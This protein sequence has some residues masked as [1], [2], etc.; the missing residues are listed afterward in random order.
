MTIVLKKRLLIL[1]S[2]PG[3]SPFL[4]N[5]VISLYAQL[6]EEDAQQCLLFSSALKF[7]L[8]P[9]ELLAFGRRFS[10]EVYL[11]GHFQ[12]TSE[13][14]SWACGALTV[15]AVVDETNQFVDVSRSDNIWSVTTIL[16]CPGDAIALTYPTVALKTSLPTYRLFPFRNDRILRPRG[17]IAVPCDGST[18]LSISF[19][20]WN[21][22]GRPISADINTESLRVDFSV[23]GALS[24]YGKLFTSEIMDVE[25]TPRTTTQ[26][27]ALVNVTVD[28]TMDRTLFSQYASAYLKATNEHLDL[29]L[30]AAVMFNNNALT[31][32]VEYNNHIRFAATGLCQNLLDIS[33]PDLPENANF[34]LIPRRSYVLSAIEYEKLHAF[35]VQVEIHASKHDVFHFVCEELLHTSQSLSTRNIRSIESKYFD[36]RNL[37]LQPESSSYNVTITPNGDTTHCG[38]ACIAT[39]STVTSEGLSLINNEMG[40]TAPTVSTTTS[41]GYLATVSKENTMFE[42]TAENDISS[43]TLKDNDINSTNVTEP[44]SDFLCEHLYMRKNL[45]FAFIFHVCTSESCSLAFAITKTVSEILG[46]PVWLNSTHLLQI[47]NVSDVWLHDEALFQQCAFA[48]ETVDLKVCIKTHRVWCL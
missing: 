18:S 36:P 21:C 1:F 47:T 11:E 28:V 8:D 27:W 7:M 17:G 45:H 19:R 31:D 23:E 13:L 46:S 42:E 5:I 33:V 38:E 2:L 30:Q 9:D 41:K 43:N 22:T 14:A 4:G 32:F 29:H 15:K 16:Q 25:I 48:D 12:T 39:I 10:N 35:L 24:I 20:M 26:A 44:Q 3:D 37:L 6:P 40:T 34:F